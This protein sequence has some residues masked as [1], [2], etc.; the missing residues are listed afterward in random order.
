MAKEIMGEV[1]KINSPATK[2]GDV[3]SGVTLNP[4]PIALSYACS[5]EAPRVLVLKLLSVYQI[6]DADASE[7]LLFLLTH[8]E[9]WLDW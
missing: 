3:W 2:A 9:K 5:H 1:V 8:V 6:N 4:W 7:K